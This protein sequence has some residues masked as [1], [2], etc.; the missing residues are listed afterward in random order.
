MAAASCSSVS[1]SLSVARRYW[2]CC[3]HSQV[4][5]K[6]NPACWS[7]VSSAND[8]LV[9]LGRARCRQ[10]FV[11]PRRRP[12]NPSLARGGLF[13]NSSAANHGWKPIHQLRFE[14]KPVRCAPPIPRAALGPSTST[15]FLPLRGAWPIAFPDPS[16]DSILTSLRSNSMTSALGALVGVQLPSGRQDAVIR[17]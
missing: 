8:R 13:P 16:N 12:Q 3:A 9:V 5:K 7:A 11:D 10:L 2:R 4:R 1:R 17:S 6:K 14:S 15:R